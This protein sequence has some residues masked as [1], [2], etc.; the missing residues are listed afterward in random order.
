MRVQAVPVQIPIAAQPAAGCSGASRGFLPRGLS[1]ACPQGSVDPIV[2]LRLRAGIGQPLTGAVLTRSSPKAVICIPSPAWGFAWLTPVRRRLQLEQPLNQPAWPPVATDRVYARA[3]H[4]LPLPRDQRSSTVQCE[5]HQWDI[6]RA[7]AFSMQ[8]TYRSAR[9][10]S[11]ADIITS[12]A[13][14]LKKKWL[15]AMQPLART[16]SP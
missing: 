6:L 15:Y 8:C 9:S 1:D 2:C 10:N 5:P 3:D 7:K 13:M 12:A 14:R 4:G 16:A 11:P